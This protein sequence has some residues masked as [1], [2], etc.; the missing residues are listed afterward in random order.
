M[1]GAYIR[2]QTVKVLW[3]QHHAF[4]SSPSFCPKK[5]FKTVSSSL[6]PSAVGQVTAVCPGGIYW[7]SMCEGVVA[8]ASF[9]PLQFLILSEIKSRKY[10]AQ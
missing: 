4:L 9:I 10:S 5:V 1:K 6:K 7:M 3:L 2:C 8:A